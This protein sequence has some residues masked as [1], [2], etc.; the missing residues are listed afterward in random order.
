L[1][2]AQ[3]DGDSIYMNLGWDYLSSGHLS[4]GSQQRFPTKELGWQLEFQPSL[5]RRGNQPTLAPNGVLSR[6][7]LITGQPYELQLYP[8]RL[9][10]KVWRFELQLLCRRA[11][12]AWI[13]IKAPD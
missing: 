2:A 12:P 10:A 3:E 11:H 1:G 6:Q 9:T 7:L 13:Q 5:E 8:R 4:N